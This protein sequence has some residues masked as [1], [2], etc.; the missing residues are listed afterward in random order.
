[1]LELIKKVPRSLIIWCVIFAFLQGGSE[2][3][4][5]SLT[6]Q[7]FDQGVALGDSRAIMTTALKMLGMTILIVSF[8]V[9]NVYFA[10][11]ASLGLGR[12]LRNSLYQKVVGLPK[13][14]YEEF[15]A[16]SLITRS[17]SDVVQ[18]EQTVMMTLRMF[19]L[20]PA[21]FIAGVAMAIYTSPQLSQV[22]IFSIPMLALVMGIVIYF[23]GPLFFSMQEKVD[24]MNRIFREGLTGIRVIRAFNRNQYESDRFAGAN[25]DYQT[26]AIKANVRMGFL[27]PAITL[28][29]SLTNIGI[30]WLGGNLVSDLQL[31]VGQIIS[32]I[33]YTGIIVFSFTMLGMLFVMIPRAQV[34][35]KRINQ[36]L[37]T[38]N[39]I[40]NP[41]QAMLIDKQRP[42]QVDFNQVSFKFGDAQT[43]T[44]TDIDFHLQ[45]GQTLGIIGGTG[46]GKSTILNLILRFFDV[47]EGSVQVNGTDVREIDLNSLRDAIGYVPQKANLFSGTIRSNLQFGNENASDEALWRALDIAQAK[48]FVEALTHGL[49]SKVNQGGSNF[50]GGQKQRL[51]I[52]RA[53]VKQANINIFDDSFSALDAQTD[54]KLRQA[55]NREVQDSANIIVSQRVSTIM[56]ADQILVLDDAGNMCG[57]GHHD[58]LLANNNIY[59]SI[60]NS[61]LGEVVD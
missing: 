32:F 45:A 26:T 50:S 17:S 61:Q 21:M 29:L 4:L 53:L 22:Y 40:Q 14:Q 13:D 44:L 9:L 38:V 39:D 28:V 12:Y 18:I 11:K 35:A 10:S 48:Y 19:L 49:D 36:V 31:Q 16:A 8:A 46:S 15:G 59:Q 52:A 20:A 25:Q 5:P 33:S 3:I 30:I 24:N 34:A 37:N 23:A 7:L 6:A 2:L 47:N 51:C 58:D 57:L 42:G 41:D 60:V 27:M 55:L 43:N 54:A 1:M 56:D